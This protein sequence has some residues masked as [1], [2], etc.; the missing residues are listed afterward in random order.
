MWKDMTL[1]QWV[2]TTHLPDVKEKL[3]F[4]NA[5]WELQKQSLWAKTN[6]S[7]KRPDVYFIFLNFTTIIILLFLLN[8]CILIQAFYF[9]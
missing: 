2:E 4:K 3:F 6:N 8:F 1:F 9:F 7:L 5:P